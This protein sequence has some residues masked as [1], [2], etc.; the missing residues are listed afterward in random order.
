MTNICKVNAFPKFIVLLAVYILAGFGCSDKK[1]GVRVSSPEEFTE[2]Y[3]AALNNQN[4]DYVASCFDSKI[5]Q[6]LNRFF[7]V[8]KKAIAQRK[9]AI[10][11]F[12][13]KLN[14][15]ETQLSKLPNLELLLNTKRISKIQAKSKNI[16]SGKIELIFKYPDTNQRFFLCFDKL[17]A[18]TAN[19]R[20]FFITPKN[21][22][23]KL[24][25]FI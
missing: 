2:K 24:M 5:A 9:K 6:S 3:L 4:F 17:V 23:S 11:K 10:V 22:M 14:F 12:K 21:L 19:S 15:D 7:K 16:G 25:N 1:V 13:Q 18:C 8:N 20:W